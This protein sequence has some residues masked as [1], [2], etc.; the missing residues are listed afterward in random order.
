ME[1]AATSSDP[2]HFQHLYST[3]NS[4]FQN[5]SILEVELT[6][7]ADRLQ[8]EGEGKAGAKYDFKHFGLSN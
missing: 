5:R 6:E 8:K 3:T 2:I 7:L 4:S 1:Y